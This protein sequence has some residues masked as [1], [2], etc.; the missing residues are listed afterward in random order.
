MFSRALPNVLR[1]NPFIKPDSE[2]KGSRNTNNGLNNSSTHYHKYPRVVKDKPEYK[3]LIREYLAMEV[4]RVVSEHNKFNV[5]IP[6]VEVMEGESLYLK[7][8][9]IDSSKSL[10]TNEE[11][12]KDLWL[13]QALIIDLI[14]LNID[15]H[16]KNIILN[17]D[18]SGVT[19]F[20]F[21]LTNH[22]DLKNKS[23]DEMLNTIGNAGGRGYSYRKIFPVQ[24]AHINRLLKLISQNGT[25]EALEKVFTNVKKIVSATFPD[26]TELLEDLSNFIGNVKMMQPKFEVG[27]NLQQSVQIVPST[28]VKKRT[29][30]TPRSVPRGNPFSFDFS[31]ESPTKRAVSS[32]SSIRH[33]KKTSPC[34]KARLEDD[35]TKG[36][37][38][39]VCPT[40]LF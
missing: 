39:S 15:G 16:K 3:F 1:P 6:E 5:T 22:P 40:K 11:E 27:F 26:R 4:A 2:S 25:F 37:N 30:S 21:D 23:L 17:P 7:K 13:I 28:P 29:P 24:T 32:A 20:D 33:S 12:A 36:Q 19:L 10:S 38:L 34:K 35:G 8:A 9:K 31:G 18:A 14:T